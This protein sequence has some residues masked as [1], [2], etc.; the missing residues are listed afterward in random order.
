MKSEADPVAFGRELRLA[1]EQARLSMRALAR[2]VDCS[3]E[4]VRLWE[5]GKREAN[6][7]SARHLEIALDLPKDTLMR[8]LYPPAERP[9]VTPLEQAVTA[10]S[11]L[12]ILQ[13]KALHQVLAAFRE[14]NA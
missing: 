4:A 1:R 5:A 8:W 9:A 6:P 13:R 12:T 7:S 14:D 10:D 2:R 3:V 11:T